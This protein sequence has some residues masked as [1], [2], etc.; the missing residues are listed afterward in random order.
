VKVETAAPVADSPTA[1]QAQGPAPADAGAADDWTA[2]FLERHGD[3]SDAGDRKFVTALGRGL[4]ILRV[5]ESAGDALGNQALAAATGLPKPTVSRLTYT[6]TRLGYLTYSRVLGKYQLGPAALSLGHMA[7][8]T[9]RIPAVARPHMQQFAEHF[10]L[11][12]GLGMRNGLD[13]VLIGSCHSENMITLRHG[14][15]ERLPMAATAMGRA[16]LTALPDAERAYLMHRLARRA[17]Q[18]WPEFDKAIERAR[19]DIAASGFCSSLGDWLSDISGVAVPLV[20]REGVFAVNC[21]GPTFRVGT[22]RLIREIGPELVV[23]ARNIRQ[24]A[25]Q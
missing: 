22:E 9:M 24:A 23:M 10:G 16:F 1:S 15:G 2:D 3:R 14:A 17:G 20:L 25:G 7:S 12:V 18:R 6:L 13:M 21:G 4:A 8:V 5:F 19:S 11:S